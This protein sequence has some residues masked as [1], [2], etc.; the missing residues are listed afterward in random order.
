[1]IELSHTTRGDAGWRP[2]VQSRSRTCWRPRVALGI[3]GF[4]VAILFILLQ[5][6][7]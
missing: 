2:L 1:M 4:S 5:A 7:D 6:P 3:V